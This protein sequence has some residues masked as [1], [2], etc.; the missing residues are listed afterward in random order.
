MKLNYFRLLDKIGNGMGVVP[1]HLSRGSMVEDAI[2]TG[3]LVCDLII[4]GGWPAGRWV[5]LF[6]PEAS[7]KSTLLYHTLGDAIRQDVNTEF[8]DFEG[9]T[10]PTYLSKILNMDL[11]QVFGV[12]KE[13]GAWELTPQC[14]YYQPD[15]G[16]IYFRYIHRVLQAIPDKLRHN[17]RWYYVYDKKPKKDDF[18][19]KL[20]KTT[21]RFWIPCDDGSAQVV[22]F[23]DSLPAMLPEKQDAKDESNEIGLQARM[24]SRYIPL[25]KSRL[26][27]KRCSIVAVN[28]IRLKPMCLHYDAKV[29]LADGTEKAIG[30]IVENR[31]KVDVLSYNKETDEVEAK[32]IVNWFDNGIA[33][34]GFEN[35]VVPMTGKGQRADFGITKDHFL[36]NER[37]EEIKLATLKPGDYIRGL[38]RQ[39]FNEDQMQIVL[40]SILGDGWVSPKNMEFNIAHGKEQVEYCKFKE[41]ILG[42]SNGYSNKEGKYTCYAS[43]YLV[44]NVEQLYKE[45]YPKKLRAF[46]TKKG[47]GKPRTFSPIILANFDLKALA[48]Y[49]MDD[50]HL[51]ESNGYNLNFSIMK[52]SWDE[53]ELFKEK[54]EKLT[55]LEF[56]HSYK[57]QADDVKYGYHQLY[58]KGGQ[59]SIQTFLNLIG[60]YM[61]ESMRYK[62]GSFIV[63]DF[64][65]YNWDA[66]YVKNVL[67]NFRISRLDPRLTRYSGKRHRRYDIEVGGTHNY[68]V[69]G[70]QLHN[71]FGNPEY[72]VGGQA[73]RFYSDIRLQCRSCSNPMPGKS[74]QIDEEPCWDGVGVDKYR[75]VKIAT[76]KNKC[77]SPFRNSLMRVWMEEKG[78]TGRGLDPVFDTFQYMVETG[79]AS[80]ERGGRYAITMEGPWSTKKSWRWN[81][82]KELILNPNRVEVYNKFNMNVPEI[83][84]ASEDNDETQA[85][86]AAVLDIRGICQRQ[87][88]T[89]E[90]FKL[91]FKAIC[92]AKGSPKEEEAKTCS[93]CIRYKKH[94]NCLDVNEDQPGC[95]EWLDEEGQELAMKDEMLGEESSEK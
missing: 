47:K 8:F 40:A 4:G 62:I 80:R 17:G 78:D 94:E 3:S 73:P 65:T 72:E 41:Q 32:P 7:C 89:N 25:V 12:R 13:S 85:A 24:F 11:N 93:N 63:S 56:R 26:A 91:Y 27:R 76:R 38:A 92:G 75:Y 95:D 9:S 18:D 34:E 90:A 30:E 22:W 68:F 49:Y 50:G 2:S 83:G 21:R 39:Q 37:G 14:R 20:Y 58:L 69:Q 60:L 53:G 42:L 44:A 55:G 71:S 16:E 19:K 28:Q 87:I 35:L 43:K 15:V 10:D 48:I 57:E 88:K 29:M 52:Y 77:F 82:F 81:E 59:N 66:Q 70:I 31:L 1:V 86:V 67:T 23:I 51:N 84:E 5:A 74:G 33:T 64:G 6:G 54:L 46:S 45:S 61:H 36:Y 79:Q